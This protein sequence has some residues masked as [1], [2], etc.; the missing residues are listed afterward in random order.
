MSA[1][2]T[3]IWQ[4]PAYLP[5]LQP[6]LTD[7][8]VKE[9][10]RSIGYRLPDSYLA[11]LRNQNGGYIRYTL[12]QSVHNLI[13]GIGPHFPS[14]TGFDWNDCR[15]YVS[16]Q[17]DGLIPFDG[18]GHWY[19][20]LDYRRDRMNPSVTHVEIDCDMECE[21]APCFSDYLALLQIDAGE[22]DFLIPGISDL[23]RNLNSLADRLGVHFEPADCDTYGYP[24]YRARAGTAT[25]PEWL[26]ISPNLVPRGF[27]KP[28]DPRYEELRTL[29]PGEA[30]QYPEL[31]DSSYLLKVTD[32]LRTAALRA[33]KELSIDIRPLTEYAV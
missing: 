22:G 12:P 32:G 2:T 4:V 5:Y 30:Y 7:Q 26:W 29:L 28:D 33:C 18:D 17:L 20:C 3:T 10:E 15:E 16:Y 19:L 31:P 27:V 1:L 14:V 8:M 11:L 25:N 9:A 6:T 24:V 21:V 23:A 13:Y